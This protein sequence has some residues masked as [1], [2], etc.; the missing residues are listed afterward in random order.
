MS[1]L[2]GRT[3]TRLVVVALVPFLAVAALVWSTT[4]R[5]DK[6]DKIPVAVVNNDQIITGPQPM[7]A[8]RSLA[9]AL[10]QPKKPEQNLDWTLTDSGDAQSG[11]TEGSYYAVLTIPKDFSKSILSTGTDKPEQ[12]NLSLVSNTAASETVPYI[13]QQVAAAAADA[14]GVQSTQGY[15]KNVYAGFNQIASSNQK[16]A[17]SASSL[18][19]GTSQVSEGAKQLD[20][21]TS[22]L[23]GSLDQVQ[24]GAAALHAGAGSLAAG[25]QGVRSGAS[26]VSAGARSLHTGAG[27]LATSSAKLAHSSSQLAAAS[28]KI[29]HGATRLAVANHRLSQGNRLVAAELR[30]L[31]RVCARSP[32]SGLL[33][34]AVTRV[35]GQA[36]TL[37]RASTSVSHSAARLA[38]S[39][40]R[41]SAGTGRLA[42][43]NAQLSAGA[44][45]L[46]AAS[47]SL[48]HGADSLFSGATSVAQGAGNLDQSA[49]SLESGTSQTASAGASL[50]SGASSLSSSAGQVDNGAQQL[51]SGLA[52]GAKQSPTYSSSEQKAL[53]TVVSQPVLL[54][55][56]LQNDQHGN[57]WLLGLVIGLVLFLTALLG[58]LRRDVA[59]STGNG[60]LPVSSRRLVLAELLPAVGLAVVEGLAAM[61]AL[62]AMRVSVASYPPLV[63]LTVVAA[64]TFTTL[65]FA[66][67][68]LFG[69]LGLP[70][71][72]LFL[73]VQAAALG[74]VV[75]LETA[76][77]VLRM[78]NGVLPLT[79]YVDGASQ[80]VSGGH[81]GSPVAA[82][83][84][85]L[86]W[87]L[88]AGLAAV[89]AVGRRRVVPIGRV[90]AIVPQGAV[91]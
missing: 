23:S 20:G 49:G 42:H 81:A 90:Q 7:A 32:G 21:G 51:S 19:D 43:G 47:G 26:S 14:L 30:A 46:D 86:V 5:G 50:A 77:A 28:R 72:V 17:S 63:L 4:G 78:L 29:S 31:A 54:S 57:G 37:A 38:T 1:A 34:R 84:V 52:K 13:S 74:N 36:S 87:G 8:G 73:L 62:L 64:L 67:R 89:L 25:A 15:L 76:P 68:V 24:S 9:A 11:L 71:L 75:P 80:L 3:W 70:L 66:A 59:A 60:G 65:A 39:T 44:R 16:S 56:S 18:A 55:H 40:H 91:P 12:G 79:A 85:L 10:T 27:K 69:R 53:S 58:A 41:L 48:S 6:V 61:L 22:S 2:W 33:C 45:K 83:V 35:S 82:L 88:V